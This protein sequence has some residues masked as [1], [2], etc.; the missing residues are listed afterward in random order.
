MDIFLRVLIVVTAVGFMFP[1]GSLV[2]ET[3]V[4]GLFC[5]TFFAVGL[6]AIMFP[7]G[8]IGW[9]KAFH[10]E[11]DPSDETLWWVPR[12]LGAGFLIFGLIVGLVTI[13]RT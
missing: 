9:A 11:L 1:P 12:L 10:R 6:W 2:S 8:I 4:W 3:A 13:V 7:P 5:I